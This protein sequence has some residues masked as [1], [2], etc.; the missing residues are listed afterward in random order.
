MSAVVT[1]VVPTKNRVDLLR[2][3]LRSILAQQGVDV[4]VVIIDDG[5]DPQVGKEIAALSDERVRVIHN[6]SS[7]GVAAA[8]NQGVGEARTPWVAFCDDD[9]LWTPGKLAVQLGAAQ[10]GGRA[11]AYTGAVK[12]ELGPVV[13]QLM[14]PP[15]PAEVIDRLA[16]KC[17]VPAGASN[18]LADRQTVLDA[19]GFDEGLMHHADWDMWLRLLELGPPAAAPGIGVGYRLHP[20]TMSLRPDA[21]LEELQ[22]I[23]SRWR[24]L[25]GGRALDPG[26]THLWIAM[27]HLRAGQRRAAARAYLRAARTRPRQGLRGVLRTVHPASPTP[28]H[29][30]GADSGNAPALK[31]VQEVTLPVETEQMLVELAT[32]PADRSTDDQ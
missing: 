21:I 31:R 30:T 3:T 18:V 13:W 11:W 16:D 26:P 6:A 12:F 22:T 27:S 9:D 32:R 8:R 17:I 23:D 28:A 25:R 24:H 7:R 19:G 20:G 5:S 1:A 4:A 10:D 14:P 2:V 15:E 29:R